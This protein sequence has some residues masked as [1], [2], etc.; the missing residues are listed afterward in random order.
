MMRA[1]AVCLLLLIVSCTNR[2]HVP[3][4]ILQP[5]S[6]AVLMREMIIA[7]QY[8]AQ[9]IMKDSTKKDKI[10]ENQQL[11]EDIFQLHHITRD[12]FKKSLSFYEARPDL[13]K[14]LFDS[15]SAYAARHQKE[16][17]L[18]KPNLKQHGKPAEK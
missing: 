11:M 4:E 6:M 18:P 14:I 13:N 16:L 7:S 5:D 3:K 15:M 17:Y 10:K 9:S 8:A 12:E 2:T 1:A